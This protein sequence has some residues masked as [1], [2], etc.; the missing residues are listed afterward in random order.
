MTSPELEKFNDAMGQILK[1]DPAKVKAQMEA[2]KNQREEQRKNKRA[3][4]SSR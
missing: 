2:E 1:A 4:E 3:E